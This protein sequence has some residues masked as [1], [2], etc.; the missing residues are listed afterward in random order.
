MILN[1]HG[2][3]HG[4]SFLDEAFF[5]DLSPTI[6]PHPL[7]YYLPE[8]ARLTD[9]PLWQ[10]KPELDPQ[11][12]WPTYCIY[13][14]EISG[15]DQQ[16]PDIISALKSGVPE[17]A[18][19]HILLTYF[20][21]TEHES[22]LMPLTD[23]D[24]IIA[25]AKYLYDHGEQPWFDFVVQDDFVKR[26]N[27]N[28]SEKQSASLYTDCKNFN[29]FLTKV[30]PDIHFTLEKDPHAFIK[31]F[32][33]TKNVETFNAH[34][35][36]NRDGSTTIT[37]EW[38]PGFYT[39]RPDVKDG[40][41]EVIQKVKRNK[42]ERVV[43]AILEFDE[44]CQPIAVYLNH[45]RDEKTTER[46]DILEYPHEPVDE[47]TMFQ[48]AK[49]IGNHDTLRSSN[50]PFVFAKFIAN[51]PNFH[52]VLATFDPLHA[53]LG[54]AELVLSG[55]IGPDEVFAMDID[56]V[57]SPKDKSDIDYLK[58]M[59]ELP[60]L[61]TVP[62]MVLLAN[63]P[64]APIFSEQDRS[65][66][67]NTLDL[68]R[69]IELFQLANETSYVDTHILYKIM[70]IL[71][72]CDSQP[73]ILSHM[74]LPHTP[75]AMLNIANILNPR[76]LEILNSMSSAVRPIESRKAEAATSLGKRERLLQQSSTQIRPPVF[77]TPTDIEM[78]HLINKPRIPSMKHC[79]LR[80]MRVAD[81]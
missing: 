37:V 68:K 57:S 4:V 27:T 12:S 80:A 50:N 10:A 35:K 62:I 53:R 1:E 3:Q 39:P 29:D 71:G 81:L 67:S 52:R 11:A 55:M 72:F 17:K 45:P 70:D 48:P 38:F 5:V 77:C 60:P 74:P 75:G 18:I 20:G 15:L 8:S 31:I 47:Q 58:R 63:L 78:I 36:R 40:K 51:N 13:L 59:L 7:G 34:F 54:Y 46:K 33:Q 9:N 42:E 73:T 69:L 25:Y 43:R 44:K 6:N 32:P 16:N 21:L 24:S 56:L 79:I 64:H 14:Q 28:I 26:T 22:H 76:E 2:N 61:Q 23:L 49:I 19:A 65:I 41:K 30:L 66:I